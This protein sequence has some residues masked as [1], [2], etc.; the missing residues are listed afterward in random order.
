MNSLYKSEIAMLKYLLFFS[1]FYILVLAGVAIAI[2]IIDCSCSDVGLDIC[3]YNPKPGDPVCTG[4]LNCNN[5]CGSNIWG[6]CQ[7]GGGPTPPPADAC[8]IDSHCGSCKQCCAGSPNYCSQLNKNCNLQPRPGCGTSEVLPIC[9]EGCSSCGEYKRRDCSTLSTGLCCGSP[10]AWCACSSGGKSGCG[11]CESNCGAASACD[12]V[13]PGTG[14]CTSNCQ[15]ACT[16]QCTSGSTR[17]VNTLLQRCELVSGCY[18]WFS[19]LSCGTGRTC[20]GSSCVTIYTYPYPYPTPATYPYPYPTP[21]TYPYPYPTPATYPYPYPTPVTYP[22]PTPYATPPYVTPYLTPPYSTPYAYP[23]PYATPPTT[24]GVHGDTCTSNGDCNTGLCCTEG[25]TQPNECH[26]ETSTH[27]GFCMGTGSGTTTTTI[28]TTCTRANP[29]VGI[30]PP[31]QTGALNIARTYDVIV[32]NR[33]TSLCGSSTF[34]LSVSCPHMWI[35]NLAQTSLT[36]E[37][38]A[39]SSTALN[40]VPPLLSVAAPGTYTFTVTATNTVA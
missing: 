9:T 16:N 10:T 21:V 4:G 39:T 30:D 15:V 5:V 26:V 24:G 19:I 8:T 20:V 3:A 12:G 32:T 2:P 27:G 34:A 38:G 37:P 1:I 6:C 29:Y 11:I 18:K 40:V 23:T 14:G 33:D 17:C 35:C 22:Y 7:S 36:L 25:G 28:S 13:P 31:V